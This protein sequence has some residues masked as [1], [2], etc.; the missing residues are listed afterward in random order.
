MRK[1]DV[2]VAKFQKM[3]R[4]LLFLHCFYPTHKSYLVRG[5]DKSIKNLVYK[6]KKFKK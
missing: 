6:D 1:N 4:F 2:L 5:T 3:Q